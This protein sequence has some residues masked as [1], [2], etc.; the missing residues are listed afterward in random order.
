MYSTVRLFFFSLNNILTCLIVG[1]H[2]LSFPWKY[3]TISAGVELDGCSTKI[4]E[5]DDV[6]DED[7]EVE[8]SLVLLLI[9]Y[10]II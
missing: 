1:P 2:T 5:L 8:L 7:G 10:C 4:A 6:D 9:V 3:R